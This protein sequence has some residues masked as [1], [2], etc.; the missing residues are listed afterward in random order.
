KPFALS[1]EMDGIP[2]GSYRL[3]AELREGEAVMGTLEQPIRLVNGIDARRAD[4]VK[5]LARIEGHDS[6]KPSIMYPFDLVRVVNIGR[7]SY[8]AADLGI[9]EKSQP[10]FL[11]FPKEM[12]RSED[13]LA[14][15]EA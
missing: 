13:L 15:L 8:N 4:I 6:T 9:D 12:K 14:A 1:A 10:N 5:R 3:I 7:R 2:D 11:D